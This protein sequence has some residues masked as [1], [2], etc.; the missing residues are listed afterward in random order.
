MLMQSPWDMALAEGEGQDAEAKEDQQAKRQKNRHEDGDSN[1]VSCADP[2]TR[3]ETWTESSSKSFLPPKGFKPLVLGASDLGTQSL[4]MLSAL[5]AKQVWHI[6]A[7]A[8]VDVASIKE[9][10]LEAVLRG[11]AILSE[12]GVSY[13]MQEMPSDDSS[14]MLMSGTSG[15]YRPSTAKVARSFRL[16]VKAGS[17]TEASP[18]PGRPT[19]VAQRTGQ[20]RAARQQPEG[21]GMQ[22][23]PFG[24]ET[25]ARPG[26]ATCSAQQ[27]PARKKTTQA[28]DD[29]VTIAD[30]MLTL[31]PSTAAAVSSGRASKK[32]KEAKAAK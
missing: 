11:E 8:S 2:R 27:S 24:S 28:A 6:C 23:R 14:L 21:L 9:L 1:V 18:A 15:I 12:K 17:G 5:D 16:A 13:S 32:S 29:D 3:A 31:T 20:K 4:E 30:P 7:P 25:K 26:L 10:D 19:F 22:Y